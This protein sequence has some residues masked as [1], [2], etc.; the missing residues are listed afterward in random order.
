[1][2]H[3][4]LRGLI[5]IISIWNGPITYLGTVL[6]LIRISGTVPMS[7]RYKSGRQSFN[8][9][10]IHLIVS[11]YRDYTSIIRIGRDAVEGGGGEVIN[12]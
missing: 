12:P 10:V 3:I 6:G 11:G 1:M 2:V 7:R 4:E 8:L 5:T 9:R